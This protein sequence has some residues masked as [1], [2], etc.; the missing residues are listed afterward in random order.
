MARLNR[1]YKHGGIGWPE[2]A[3]V[4][5]APASTGMKI[6]RIDVFQLDMPYSG[7]MYYLSGGREYPIRSVSF[8][9]VAPT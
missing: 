3:A 4:V 9:G 1:V 5:A 7:G 8:S 2:T 6:K